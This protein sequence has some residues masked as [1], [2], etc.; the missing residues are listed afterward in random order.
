MK[1]HN[2]QRALLKII[3]LLL[4]LIITSCSSKKSLRTEVIKPPIVSLDSSIKKVG[5]LNRSIPSEENKGLDQLDKILS[6][7]GANLDKEGA[8][9]AVLALKNELTKNPRFI[10]SKVIESNALSNPGGG[11][12]PSA[13][14][15]DVIDQLCKENN[16]DAIFVLAIYDTDAKATYDT[17]AKDIKGPLGV[18]IPGLEHI[19]KIETKIY[20]GWRVYDPVKRRISDELSVNEKTL[21]KGKGVN[22]VKAI[23]AAKNR[24]ESVLQISR[25]IGENYALRLLPYKARVYR[26]YYVSATPNFEIAKR[27]VETGQWEGASELW[28]KE[29]SNPNPKIAGQACFNMA[30]YNEIKGDYPKAIEWA[31]KSYTDYENKNALDYI[32]DLKERIDNQKILSKS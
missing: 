7:E 15:W 30:F 26:D 17:A 8:N 19:V 18:K 3:T 6:V 28:L 32:D 12:F 2:F 9:Q 25:K 24:K 16:V 21:S 14:S 4:F 23:E 20:T 10:E 1:S 5:V 31:T 11:V 13:L 27:K 29:T 22:P